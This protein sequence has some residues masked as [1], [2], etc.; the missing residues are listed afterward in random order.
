MRGC[1][2]GLLRISSRPSTNSGPIRS[3]PFANSLNRSSNTKE[4]LLSQLLLRPIH[5]IRSGLTRLERGEFGVKLD[6]DQQDEFGEL[7][8]SFNSVSAQL[9]ADL[10]RAGMHPFPLPNGILLDEERPQLSACV[11]CAPSPRSTS[12]SARRIKVTRFAGVSGS[13]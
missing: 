13:S 2:N 10:T 8:A 11:R 4:T 1:R 12:A 6:L 5:V 7:G 3:A 9:S